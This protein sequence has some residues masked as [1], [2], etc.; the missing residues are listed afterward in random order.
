MGNF[1]ANSK[2]VISFKK[3]TFETLNLKIVKPLYMLYLQIR[4]TYI[5]VK[6]A[7]EIILTVTDID[8]GYKS[9]LRVKF[10]KCCTLLLM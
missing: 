10:S 2:L 1:G 5:C 8:S 7:R 3:T 9:C 6:M 4:Y